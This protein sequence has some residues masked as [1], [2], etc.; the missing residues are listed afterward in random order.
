[1]IDMDLE[2]DTVR[3]NLKAMLDACGDDTSTLQEHGDAI[4]V[5][6]YLT[7]I[8]SLNTD[9]TVVLFALVPKLVDTI[10]DAVRDMA[11][12]EVLSSPWWATLT[13][14]K[15]SQEKIKHFVLVTEAPLTAK[16]QQIFNNVDKELCE[17]KSGTFSCFLRRELMYNPHEHVLVPKHRVL[18][19]KEKDEVMSTYTVEHNKKLPIISKSDT[20]ARWLRGRHGDLFEIT[21]SNMTSGEYKYYRH[22]S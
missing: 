15:P 13:N 9:R 1:M 8:I 5:D 7:D 11:A 2:L 14:S 16:T 18:S 3:L 17:E 22:C 21:R 10:K 20:M 4:P 12:P 6:R 19:D